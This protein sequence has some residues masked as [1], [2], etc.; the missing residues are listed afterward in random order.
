MRSLG[1]CLS[2]A[3]T[4]TE[5]FPAPEYTVLFHPDARPA[6]IL[7]KSNTQ[8]AAAQ[9]LALVVCSPPGRTADRYVSVGMGTRFDWLDE[10]KLH[11]WE[12][13]AHEPECET[14]TSKVLEDHWQAGQAHD[15][16]T[17]FIGSYKY[18]VSMGDSTQK[19]LITGKVRRLRR[20]Q[21]MDPVKLQQVMDLCAAYTAMDVNNAGPTRSCRVW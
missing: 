4:R 7:N 20:T 15:I 8:R 11:R 6:A 13:L 1:P 16:M 14:H 19:N 17:F 5:T 12:F 18:Q 2:A 10:L 9:A 21:A 3:N